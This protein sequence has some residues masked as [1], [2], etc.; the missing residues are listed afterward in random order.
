MGLVTAAVSFLLNSIRPG[1]R[2][3]ITPEPSAA[4]VTTWIC[5]AASF[6]SLTVPSGSCSS[7][8]ASCGEDSSLLA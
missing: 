5:A 7:A 8:L 2:S 6:D 3:R 4:T 1:D